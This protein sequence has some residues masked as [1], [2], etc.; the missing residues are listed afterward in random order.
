MSTLFFDILLLPGPR[1]EKSVWVFPF[2]WGEHQC[3]GGWR[4]S[5]WGQGPCCEVLNNQSV[6]TKFLFFSFSKNNIAKGLCEIYQILLTCLL[7]T[8]QSHV[9]LRDSYCVSYCFDNAKD[10]ADKEW[11]MPFRQ[12]FQEYMLTECILYFCAQMMEKVESWVICIRLKIKVECLRWARCRSPTCSRPL[13]CPPCSVESTFLVQAFRFLHL[14]LSCW[15][16]EEIFKPPKKWKDKI[17][18]GH[19]SISRGVLW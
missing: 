7:V 14:W 4:G 1:G 15:G 19:F 6:E 3:G 10:A 2:L 12:L 13:S 9:L 16:Q 5:C 8:F 11:L 17:Y 18:V